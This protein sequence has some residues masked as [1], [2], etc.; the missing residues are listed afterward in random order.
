MVWDQR[1]ILFVLLLCFVFGLA[2][3]ASQV[4]QPTLSPE[5][6]LETIVAATYA[7]V[8]SASPTP[9]TVMPIESATHSPS[10]TP[11]P[12]PTDTTTPS[13]TQPVKNV[14]GMVCFPGG[15]IPAMTIFFEDTENEKVIELPI[16]AGQKSYEQSLQPGT[17]IAYAWLTDFSRG[18]LYSKAVQCG[19]TSNCDDHT[20]LPFTLSGSE[21]NDSVDLCDWYAGPFNVP[22]P[23]GKNTEDVTGAISGSLSYIQGKP[24]ELRVVAFNLGTNYWY[25]VYTL[26]GQQS[27]TLSNLPAGIY[28]VV[29]YDNSGHAGGYA[30]A[31]HSLLPVTVKPGE[32]SKGIN[33][34]DWDAPE[35]SFPPDP[36][37]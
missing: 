31:D 18:G 14:K 37:R 20:V 9:A 29:A 6:Q 7:A 4:K 25:W 5:N 26:S 34:S 36:T 23:P 15:D 10:S 1:K 33:I 35:G 8:L 22:Y 16:D 24:P 27:Y 11:Q 17:Y 19:L 3:C 21:V 28:N 30:E 32:T 13:P 12:S 2:A